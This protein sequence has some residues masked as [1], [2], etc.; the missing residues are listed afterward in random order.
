MNAPKDRSQLIEIEKALKVLDTKMR[1]EKLSFYEP[2]KKQQE[3][4]DLGLTKIERLLMAGNQQGKT[5]CGAAEMAMHLTGQY[6]ADWMGRRFEKPVRAWVAAPTGLAVRDCAQ[7]HLVGEL[8]LGYG[9]GLIPRECL[10]PDKMF[11]AR[12][13]SNLYDVVLVKHRDG[14][15]RHN[16]WS[17]L[18][19]K[20]YEMG[21]EKWQGET[22]DVVWLDEE[23]PMDIYT[24]ALARISATGGMIYLTFTPLKGISEVV[25]RFRSEASPLRETVNMTIDDAEHLTP[26][27]RAQI[28]DAYPEHE[29]EAR[30]L[31]V[32]M[33]GEGKIFKFLE[34]D[35]RIPAFEIPYHWPLLW[36]IDFGVEHPFA[37]VLMAWDRDSDTLY[38]LH[39]I[40]MKGKLP[41]DH[42]AA[43]KPFGKDVPVAWP[44]DGNQRREF[45]GQLVPMVRIYR[46]HGLKMLP[47]HATFE[48]GS[49]SVEAGL[50]MMQERFRLGKLKVFSHCTEWFEEY[51]EYHRKEGLIVK[52]HDDL[53]SATRYGVMARRMSRTVGVDPVSG[54]KENKI[55]IAK[56][57]DFDVF[58]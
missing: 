6:A 54:R 31:G 28:I 18:T 22:L 41:I 11:L 35:I 1:T 25:R 47:Q 21:R 38:V 13:V 24:E 37:A 52:E 12:G 17:Q 49:N 44:H 43:M 36:A 55:T 14:K 53:M 39:C 48:D 16:G 23:P 26:E 46:N 34:K 30:T 10:S 7:K 42:A 2:Y 15:N 8:G 57:T 50:M 45:E 19:F 56:D 51:R 5:Y 58:S 3:F 4:H 33:L 40:R 27:R 32:P 20:T 29:R 9:T